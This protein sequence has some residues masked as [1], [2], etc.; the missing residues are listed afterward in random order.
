M[1]CLLNAA[2]TAALGFAVCSCTI[3]SD[4]SSGASGATSGSSGGSSTASMN[5]QQQ[6]TEFA[7]INLEQLRNDMAAGEGEYLSSLAVLLAIEP[8]RQPA[9]FTLAREKFRVLFPSDRTSAAEMLA[10][11]EQEMRANPRVGQRVTLN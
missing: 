9:F 4:P 2:L 8:N 1:K 5:R 7:K 10:A 6:A 3:V 11:L